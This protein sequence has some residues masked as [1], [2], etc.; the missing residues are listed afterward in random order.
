MYGMIKS[1]RDMNDLYPV[2]P[3]TSCEFCPNVLWFDLEIRSLPIVVNYRDG[4]P[5][6]LVTSLNIGSDRLEDE[7][8]L[9]IVGLLAQI[10]PK[11]RFLVFQIER[12]VEQALLGV[13]RNCF[14]Y[15]LQVL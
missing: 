14:Q 6:T 13:D 2:N 5:N 15:Q 8:A 12:D 9:F 1:T 7:L 10:S 4:E 3:E 11:I